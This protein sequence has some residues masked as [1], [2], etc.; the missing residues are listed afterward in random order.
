MLRFGANIGMLFAEYS[1]LERF[2]RAAAAGF[3]AIEFP[4]PYE[5]NVREISR[6]LTRNGL[7]IVQF[8]LPWA[9]STGRQ[10]GIANDPRR[11]PEFREGVPRALEIANLLRC[12]R[13]HCLVGIKLPDVP[14]DTQWMTVVENLRHAA[15][16]G[17]AAGVRI[18]VEPLNHFD[19]PGFLLTTMAQAVRL[20]D[21]VKH[22]NVRILC[23]VYHMQRME[24]NLTE[25]IVT[26]LGQIEHFEIA[27]SP[28]RHQPGTGEIHY[29]FLLKAI[30]QAGYNG[31]VCLEY[32]PLGSTESSLS[33]LRE[34]GYWG[35][36]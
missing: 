2:D 12:P 27:D 8:N 14:I 13:V 5:E 1:F 34:W 30:D 33:W 23:D 11:K 31:W 35:Q 25:T 21:E 28:G 17:A 3:E 9:D 15:E 36:V 22:D 18:L 10:R 7:Q 20:L 29:P 32:R 4:Q 19:V 24:G 6:A 26:N 16:Q